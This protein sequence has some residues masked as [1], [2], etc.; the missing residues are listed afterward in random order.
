MKKKKNGGA[1]QLNS[2]S[3]H[4]QNHTL[5]KPV[6]SNLEL[7]RLLIEVAEAVQPQAIICVTETGALAQRLYG[8]L[9]QFRVIAAT[10]N[11]DT[12]EALTQTGFQA[13]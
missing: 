9:D 2:E 1:I 6:H 13:I 7:V 10:T 3:N 12:Y 4:E 5:N 8:L 11:R